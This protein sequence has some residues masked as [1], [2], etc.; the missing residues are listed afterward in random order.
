MKKRRKKKKQRTE[1]FKSTEH[2][3]DFDPK[4][5]AHVMKW[6]LSKNQ[7]RKRLATAVGGINEVVQEAYISLLKHPPKTKFKLTTIATKHASW[8]LSRMCSELYGLR[9]RTENVGL[10]FELTANDDVVEECIYRE[11]V[12][13]VWKI[14][15]K[16]APL[17]TADIIKRRMHG[18]TFTMIGET[19]MVTLERVRQL[20]KKGIQKL[21]ESAIAC[22]RLYKFDN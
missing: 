5:I 6:W 10:W 15:E 14:V 7:R 20:E 1:A 12:E 3:N 13:E 4:E 17:R 2:L 21:A 19:H 22:G 11:K 9:H 18:E 16:F 8:T